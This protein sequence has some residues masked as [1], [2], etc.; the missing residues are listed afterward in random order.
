MD[1]APGPATPFPQPAYRISS[2]PGTASEAGYQ[3]AT[4]ADAYGADATGADATGADAYGADAGGAN[5]G[6][7][8]AGGADAGAR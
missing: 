2:T 8:D 6:G 5:A 4:D 3:A 1:A 7:A